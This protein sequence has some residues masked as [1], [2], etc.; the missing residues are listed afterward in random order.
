[1]RKIT[2]FHAAGRSTSC[3]FL[4]ATF[5]VSPTVGRTLFD[6]CLLVAMRAYGTKPTC[7]DVRY[8][9]VVRVQADVTLI[10][11]DFA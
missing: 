1:V 3:D 4:T 9:S 5:E 6:V 2:A 7:R 8:W 10:F 11:A